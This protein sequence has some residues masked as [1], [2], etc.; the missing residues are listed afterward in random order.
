[1][2]QIIQSALLAVILALCSASAH[3]VSYTVQATYESP[4]IP[5]LS[6]T[7]PTFDGKFDLTTV[8]YNPA[9]MN[10][11]SAQGSFDIS[12]GSGSIS[13][14]R[15]RFLL[16][17]PNFEFVLEPDTTAPYHPLGV[18]PFTLSTGSPAFA[19]LDSTGILHFR[20]N[21]ATGSFTFV[22]GTLSVPDGGTTA[23]LLGCGLLGLV[24]VQRRLT[25]RTA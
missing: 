20:I 15:F 18:Y 22:S 21:R 16:G 24:L 5:E 19:T 12:T 4:E 14:I 9:T 11:S 1:M 25:A 3:A 8:G 13:Q 7:N 2:K 6:A 23:I 10:I 17:S